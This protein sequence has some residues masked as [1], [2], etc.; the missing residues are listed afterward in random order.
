MDPKKITK[1]I[2]YKL[3]IV[4]I[5]VKKTVFVLIYYFI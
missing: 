3:L 1:Q 4:E 2:K 5:I